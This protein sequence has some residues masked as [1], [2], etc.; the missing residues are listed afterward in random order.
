M[1]KHKVILRHTPKVRMIDENHGIGG[2]TEP[3][4]VKLY[5]SLTEYIFLRDTYNNLRND[6]L[7][8][9]KSIYALTHQAWCSKYHK[10]KVWKA[11]KEI[12]DIDIELL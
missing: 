8:G 2:V 1:K 7:R 6:E 9:V 12:S 3:I 4:E 10:K 11:F 5:L